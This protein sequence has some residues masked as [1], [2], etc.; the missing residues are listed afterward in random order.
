MNI[1]YVHY[2]IKNFIFRITCFVIK[3][4][5]MSQTKK[6]MYIF[7]YVQKIVDKRYKYQ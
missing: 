7:Y 6:F 1:T 5:I 4:I 2:Y 3:S